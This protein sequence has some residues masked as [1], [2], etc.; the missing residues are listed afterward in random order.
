MII[1]LL[2]HACHSSSLLCSFA[3]QQS[4]NC[5]IHQC[6]Q[7]DT[8]ASLIL[9]YLIVSCW[10]HLRP[11]EYAASLARPPIAGE[12]RNKISARSCNLKPQPKK[13]EELKRRKQHKAEEQGMSQAQHTHTHTCALSYS[14]NFSGRTI[15]MQTCHLPGRE[16]TQDRC[17]I[18]VRLKLGRRRRA[19]RSRGGRRRART[20]SETGTARATCAPLCNANYG[21]VI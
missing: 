6:P 7:R 8:L 20:R 11:G 10:I 17:S 18:T 12:Y 15:Q 19:R 3:T 2:N 1:F 9:H 5:Q 13:K 21:L 16:Q 4:R 14:N